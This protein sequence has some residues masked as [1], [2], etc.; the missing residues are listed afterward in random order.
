MLRRTCR[1]SAADG[2]N[3]FRRHKSQQFTCS[4]RRAHLP[5]FWEG[6][7]RDSRTWMAARITLAGDVESNPGPPKHTCTQTKQTQKPNKQ[8]NTN[9]QIWI[10]LICNLE[11]KN[12]WSF[13]CKD[14]NRH[15][16]HKKCTTI[17]TEEE[18]KKYE[19]WKCSIHNQSHTTQ[20][21][22]ATQTNQNK[23]TTTTGQSTNTNNIRTVNNQTNK[24]NTTDTDK[25]HSQE[26]T[27]LQININGIQS[28]TQELI[29][30]VKDN[31]IDVIT[32]QETKLQ[33]KHKT[34][35][36]TGFSAIRKDRKTGNG[37]GLLMYI[38]ENITF[39]E[40]SID[41]KINQSH[42]EL[43]T[44]KLH[45]N[46]KEINLANIYIPPRTDKNETD[47]QTVTQC[48]NTLTTQPNIL[49]TGDV[50]A[51]SKLWHSTIE[52]HRGSTIADLITNSNLITLNA[53]SPTRVPVASNQQ[54]TSPD[55]SAISNNLYEYTTWETIQDL[56]SDHLPIKI[57]INTK[58]QFRSKDNKKMYTNYKKA[59]WQDF[60]S[61]IE[62]ALEDTTDPTDVHNSNK[63]ITNLILK[64]DKH[65]I[66]KGKINTH[67]LIL[68][69]NIRNKIKERNEL[70]KQDSKNPKLNEMNK[71]INKLIQTH[72][73][74]LWK[75]KLNENWN[76]KVNSKKFWKI[77]NNLSNK[78]PTQQLNR[79]IKF[80]NSNRIKAK[81][82]SESFNHQFT[83]ITK[84][85][86]NKSY[87]KIDKKTK[88]LPNDQSYYITTTQV[89]EAIKSSKTN[90]STGP[91]NI[92]I[93]HLKHLGTNAI[94]YLTKIYNLAIKTNTLPHMWKLAKIIPIPKPHKDLGESTSYR[95]ISLLSP[96]VK[97]L[98][99]VILPEI[100]QNITN[101]EHQ[102][103]FKA[104]HSTTTALHKIT[105]TITTGFNQKQPPDRTVVVA[106]DMS[107][108]FD[109]VNVHKLINK[110]HNTNIPQNIQKFTAN[111][112]KGRKAYT[113]YNNS[114]S[115]QRLLKTGVPQGGVLSPILFNIYTS[116]MPI[117]PHQ[118]QIESYADDI[119]T[120]TSHKKIKE[121]ENRLQPYLN[122]IFNWTQDN[123]LQLNADK[124]TATLF[125]PDPA[126]YNN[127]LS[128]TI[129]NKIIPTVKNPKFL[130]LHLDPKLTF[131]RHIEQTKEKAS[132]TINMLKA[133]TTKKWGK[134]KET[135]VA[136]YKA[137]TRPQLEY[138]ST[139]WSPIISTTNMN[140]LQTL[141]NTALR[142][143]TG[144][145]ADTDIS[146][147]HQETLVLPLETHLKL[148]ASQLKEKTKLP[149]HPLHPLRTQPKPPRIKKKTIFQE[150]NDYTTE[151]KTNVQNIEPATIINNMIQIHTKIV[152]QHTQDIP[153]NKILKTKAPEIDKL[154]N[155]LSRNTRVLLAQLRAGKSPFLLA[156]KHKINPTKYVSPLCPLCGTGEHNTEHI[157]NCIHIPTT[158]E[159]ADLWHNPCEVEGLLETWRGKLEPLLP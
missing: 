72:R 157:F 64:A 52:D 75:E 70:R 57:K 68:P 59:N 3:I 113:L 107:K 95:P 90:N 41:Q 62:T 63:L 108:A 5:V 111:Y 102:H 126:E 150:N 84:H 71:E 37:G 103:G 76:H 122:D 130:G 1:G 20:P 131:N 98:E 66:P 58:S 11:I 4:P 27:V 116:D 106:L 147:L 33:T 39:S 149:F 143:A 121:A 153:D 135:I 34:P 110:V 18:Y 155:T 36:I 78:N 14:T 86:T 60:T 115:K 21:T 96:I 2:Q 125:T 55:I 10:C 94:N 87:R 156:W 49:I 145:T 114:K 154:E 56:P 74:N 51:H 45:L 6:H 151:I 77:L 9:K 120:L 40:T 47:D 46:N 142:I 50:N 15:W 158:L 129:N 29:Q 91:D 144:C 127:T 132:K 159:V 109:T 73:T 61:E 48:F 105:N 26:L 137:I 22:Q 54:N 128:L 23:T 99:K 28:K 31:D 65:H 136:T 32:I 19:N 80:K 146:H 138:A 93:Q 133:L 118:V 13:E 140:E 97:T 44:C 141:Q 100:T 112:L 30:T 79:T 35:K 89:K 12:Q 53:D 117:P 101:L 104:N 25:P 16:V 42:I 85:A 88:N 148:H 43:Q 92:N 83:N 152:Q 38:K 124:S 123:D 7:P 139:V 17:K 67:H 119:N 8:N 82:I 134:D 69:E 24:N 81:E